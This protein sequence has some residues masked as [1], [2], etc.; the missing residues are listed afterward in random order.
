MD[1][2]N[3]YLN[4]F[5]ILELFKL[6]R[7]GRSSHRVCHRSRSRPKPTRIVRRFELGPNCQDIFISNEIINGFLF[8]FSSL[9]FHLVSEHQ[10]L[11]P[12]PLVCKSLT[13]RARHYQLV[14]W[15]FSY[16]GLCYTPYPPAPIPYP[17]PVC[18]FDL[19][20]RFR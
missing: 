19:N 20:K 16:G 14:F 7:P 12:R 11:N 1:K 3:N 9:A 4:L 13:N 2:S 6:S 5:Q 15:N 18:I 10:N 17:P 8:F